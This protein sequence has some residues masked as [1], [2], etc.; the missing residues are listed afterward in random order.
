MPTM[1]DEDV[2]GKLLRKLNR[3][4]FDELLNEVLEHPIVKGRIKEIKEEVPSISQY[5]A[6]SEALDDFFAEDY[7]IIFSIEDIYLSIIER[8]KRKFETITCSKEALID[9]MDFKIEDYVIQCLE[10]LR[11]ELEEALKRKHKIG[12]EE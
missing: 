5:E 2:E 4:F 9:S 6:E 12:G 3:M 1:N 8:L 7:N 11:D 10:M